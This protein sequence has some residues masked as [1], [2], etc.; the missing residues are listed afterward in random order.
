M[1]VMRLQHG[2]IAA[3]LL[4]APCVMACTACFGDPDSSQTQGMNA[5]ILTLLIVTFGVLLVA[6][7]VVLQLW[8]RAKRGAVSNASTAN[9]FGGGLQETAGE[10]A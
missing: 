4:H 9:V 10:E 1:A 8:L 3:I 6:G 2:V 7:G 5:A